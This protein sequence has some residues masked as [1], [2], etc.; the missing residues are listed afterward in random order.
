MPRPGVDASPAC[1]RA[2][3]RKAR[4]PCAIPGRSLEKRHHA[5]RRRPARAGGRA[6]V[7]RSARRGRQAC[8]EAGR[9]RGRHDIHAPIRSNDR[10]GRPGVGRPW[11]VRRRP[12]RENVPRRCRK[13]RELDFEMGPRNSRASL[14]S[15]CA[16]AVCPLFP[17]KDSLPDDA[18]R[19][20]AAGCRRHGAEGGLRPGFDAGGTRRGPKPPL[21]TPDARGDGF[22]NRCVPGARRRPARCAIPRRPSPPP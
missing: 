4:W 9:G 7:R 14:D 8:T 19:E 10:H 15:A 16:G 22:Q 12:G 21:S 20:S 18:P 6:R 13:A 17:K 1:F 11:C 2:R 5:M 3:T